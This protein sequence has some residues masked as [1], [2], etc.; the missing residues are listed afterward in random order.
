MNDIQIR[1]K[2]LYP[3]RKQLHDPQSSP[4][5]TSQTSYASH[6]W[7]YNFPGKQ[8]FLLVWIYINRYYISESTMSCKSRGRPHS[9]SRSYST[10]ADSVLNTLYEEVTEEDDDEKTNESHLPYDYFTDLLDSSSS[11]HLASKALQKDDVVTVNSEN[12]GTMTRTSIGEK[13]DSTA[14][15]STNSSNTSCDVT[16]A[17]DD[18]S[19][20]IGTNTL[21][22]SSTFD[23]SS[24][25]TMDTIN[26]HPRHF[27][28]SWKSGD[29]VRTF[30]KEFKGA[31][32]DTVTSIYQVFH[33]FTLSEKDIHEVTK[34]IRKAKRQ[35]D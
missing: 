5:N 20:T 11:S 8:Y 14:S 35:L 9:R 12:S 17:T 1:T 18:E 10:S 34:R 28:G 23:A 25:A 13:T 3:A 2:K 16:R 30:E 26:C 24:V 4:L 27:C 33:A 7:V 31:L 21:W 32:Q 15:T 22:E 6:S 19:T 29:F